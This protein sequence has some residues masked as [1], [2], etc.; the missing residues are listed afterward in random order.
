MFP[1]KGA[2]LELVCLECH[3]CPV[4]CGVTPVNLSLAPEEGLS[5]GS[6][7]FLDS[8]FLGR[9]FFRKYGSE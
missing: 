2:V 7:I 8:F 6:M 3:S 4:S 5:M 1:G 9:V